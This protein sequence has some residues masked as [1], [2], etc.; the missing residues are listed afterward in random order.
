M[1]FTW[2]P[3]VSIWEALTSI[4]PLAKV[5]LPLSNSWIWPLILELCS[6]AG[7][8]WNKILE[9]FGCDFLI[10]KVKAVLTLYVPSNSSGT[11]SSSPT[12]YKVAGP[13]AISPA[14]QSGSFF[15]QK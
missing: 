6:N 8:S 9:I 14:S 15:I 13:S 5:E 10:S 11:L 3:W 2:P 7:T 12:I 1:K 4:Y